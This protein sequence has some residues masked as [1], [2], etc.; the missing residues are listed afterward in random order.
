MNELAL[1]IINCIGAF[2]IL[3]YMVMNIEK[4]YQYFSK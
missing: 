1:I 2:T 3:G 4:L